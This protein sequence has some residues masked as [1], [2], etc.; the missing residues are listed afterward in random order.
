[1]INIASKRVIFFYL[2]R[3]HKSACG[4]VEAPCVS[5]ALYFIV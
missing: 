2:Y 3:E 5:E 4:E 1:M